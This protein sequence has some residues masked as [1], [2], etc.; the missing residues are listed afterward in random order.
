LPWR[1]FNH[2]RWRNQKKSS[3]R[4][5]DLLPSFVEVRRSEV[6]ALPPHS[7]VELR[8]TVNDSTAHPLV[9]AKTNL[10]ASHSHP[11]SA[12]W[13]SFTQQSY[14]PLQRFPLH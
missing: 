4:G 11:A 13:L 3:L 8:L 1:E 7:A 5:M 9:N 12:G 2:K 14:Q 6:A 10:D